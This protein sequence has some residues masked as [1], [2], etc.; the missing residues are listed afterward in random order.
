MQ[1]LPII[2]NV[3]WY[4]DGKAV[5]TARNNVPTTPGKI[6]LNVWPGT[7]VDSWLSKYNGKTPLV[8]QYDWVSFTAGK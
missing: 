7:G 4:V 5:Y 8:A 3:T 6:M 1:L 2:K